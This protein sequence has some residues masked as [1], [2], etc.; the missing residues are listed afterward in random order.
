MRRLLRALE[1][2]A[3]TQDLI[4][5]PS[6]AMMNDRELLVAQEEVI[7]EIRRR[8]KTCKDPEMRK[9]WNALL[10]TAGPQV[11][12]ARARQDAADRDAAKRKEEVA[13]HLARH[14][15]AMD[16]DAKPLRGNSRKTASRSNAGKAKAVSRE[17]P[18]WRLAKK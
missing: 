1:R 18:K 12:A 16:Q 10:R 15:A 13:A 9:K 6:E 2:V 7:K 17:V 14:M 4:E 5:R 11:K 8:V 3:A